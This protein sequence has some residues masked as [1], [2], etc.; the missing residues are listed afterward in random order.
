MSWPSS[1]RS[2]KKAQN[3]NSN[4]NNV[5]KSSS[6]SSNASSLKFPRNN[7]NNKKDT[8]DIDEEWW[9]AYNL[10]S[11]MIESDSNNNNSDYGNFPLPC[12]INSYE[13]KNEK[14]RKLDDSGRPF[15]ASAYSRIFSY[16]GSD[17]DDDDD[18]YVD[19]GD[20]NK[21]FDDTKFHIKLPG[22]TELLISSK[23]T[24]DISEHLDTN[25]QPLLPSQKISRIY[26]IPFNQKITKKLGPY[27]DNFVLHN[28]I[29]RFKI[30]NVDE[31]RNITDVV[32]VDYNTNKWYLL[33]D[34]RLFEGW[35]KA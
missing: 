18:D 5:P 6:S 13:K 32:I 28:T 15:T 31:N 20:Y 34:P 1:Q 14:K 29:F 12:F 11:D 2:P 26:E 25:Q 27:D 9:S 3:N 24:I 17:T 4:R 23:S 22:C 33:S 35:T 10:K 7:D 16:E 19:E 8:N 21:R 30:L